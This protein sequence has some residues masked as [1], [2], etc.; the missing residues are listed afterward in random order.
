MKKRWI[1]SLVL[2]GASLFS[3]Q[4]QNAN[5]GYI[6]PI[7]GGRKVAPVVDSQSGMELEIGYITVTSTDSDGALNVSQDQQSANQLLTQINQLYIQIYNRYNSNVIK[8]PSNY[9]PAAKSPP[10]TSC[11]HR[12]SSKWRQS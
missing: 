9:T 3:Y 12:R 6:F 10:Q 4:G 1:L 8:N 2:G 11:S 7:D 5:P